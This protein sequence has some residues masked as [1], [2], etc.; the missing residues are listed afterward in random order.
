MSKRWKDLGMVST[1]EDGFSVHELQGGRRFGQVF[2]VK[3]FVAVWVG[4]ACG[5]DAFE[6]MQF[7]VHQ[8]RRDD[9]L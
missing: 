9:I 7:A 3:G 6:V 2:G 4:D 5:F 1:F 8:V